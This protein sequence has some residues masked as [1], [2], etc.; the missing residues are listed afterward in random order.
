MLNFGALTGLLRR[1]P[2]YSA[3]ATLLRDGGEAGSAD[4]I[5]AARAVV[6][7]ALAEDLPAP[8][9]VVAPTVERARQLAE[10]LAMWL[11][12]RAMLFPAPEPLPYERVPW[13][14]ATNG[15][16]MRVLSAL[17]GLAG[18]Q[19]VVVASVQSLL[20]PLPSPAALRRRTRILRPG[21]EQPLTRL[22]ELLAANGY[23]HEPVTEV[24]GTYSRRGG[25][26][27]VFPVS[28]DR[29]IRIDYFG[30]MIDT[31][32]WFD[33]ETQRSQEAC[34]RAVLTPAAEAVAE[35]PAAGLAD[36]DELDCSDC[37]AAAQTDLERDREDFSQG[38][39]P[40]AFGLYLGYLYPESH[41]LLDYL[42][43]EAVVMREEFEFAD[44]AATAFW[45]DADLA[46]ERGE[47]VGDI[48]R[49]LRAPLLP[50][51]QLRDAIRERS[52]L[53]LGVG[54]EPGPASLREAFLPVTRMAGQV[55]LAVDAV[56]EAAAAGGAL[57][58]SRQAARLAELVAERGV[59]V[60]AADEVREPVRGV[61]VVHGSYPEGWALRL[62][63]VGTVTLFTDTEVFGY[64]RPARRRP[65]KRR[66]TE[67]FTI[68][69]EPG[70]YVVHV[71]HGIGRY[72]G[73]RRLPRDG[74]EREYLEIEYAGGD[75]LYVPT[76]Q[77]D[78]IS[79]YV[80][81]SEAAPSLSGLSGA[82]WQEAKARA[83]RAVEDI[84]GEL[85]ELYLARGLAEGYTFAPDDTWQR[86]LESAFPYEETEDQLRTLAQVKADMEAPRP[87]DRLIFGDVGYG[88]T[89]V[90]LRAAF[91]AVTDGKQVA[92][93]VPTTV[94]AQQH[95]ETFRGRLSAFPVTIE[96]LSRLRS[97]GD[98][99]R[100]LERLERGEVD[101]VVGTHRLVQKDVAFKDL[102]L[103]IIDEE[104][105]F[106]VR[107]KE[108]LK[109]L[110]QQV[111]VLTMTATP[112]PRTL[113][114][115]LSGLRDMSTI[116]TP[117]EDRQPVWTQ[118]SH[119]DDSL[120]ERAIR[121]ELAR[122]GQVFLV[123]DRVLGIA[124]VANRVRRL[125][126]EAVV[127]VG[128][129]QLPE[130]KLSQVME[131]FSSGAV[132][133]LV[134]TTIIES[135]LDIPN[136]NTI[137]INHADRFGLAQ[138]YQLRG[139]VGRGTARAYAYLLFSPG[140]GVTEVARQRLRAIMEA[141]ELGAGVQIAMRD[142]E[143]R[144][145]GDVLGR[146]QSGHIT[147]VGFDL[148]SRMLAQAVSQRQE[149]AGAAPT[150]EKD[151]LEAFLRPLSPGL[152]ISLPLEAELPEDYI[153]DAGLRLSLYRQLG[154]LAGEEDVDEFAAELEER[155][156][157]PPPPVE[158]LLYQTRVKVLAQHLG[159]T[160][161]G[162][163]EDQF[164][165]RMDVSL[166]RAHDIQEE[167]SGVARLG[168][169]QIRIDASRTQ[170]W[171]GLLLW[172]LRVLV[173]IMEERRAARPTRVLRPDV[174]SRQE[175]TAMEAEG[176]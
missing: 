20:M 138:L 30:D 4:V 60:S 38:Q 70:D 152:Q 120:V 81:A 11:G 175:D 78:R 13:S 22:A 111:D 79:R 44:D 63:E 69:V 165:L 87:M 108:H 106:G 137:I 130:G 168:R 146:R 49:G 54:A 131:R 23:R 89:E 119:W 32:R 123:H 129:G 171:Q 36:L 75:R 8:M 118:V 35:V 94:L 105:R 9:L 16:R 174:R 104:Q 82:D 96:M 15:A 46:R 14:P 28:Q 12:E 51:E 140:Q 149:E 169:G 100:V 83:R 128:H 5:Q 102:G 172:A 48:P 66:V 147:A 154:A 86:E 47:S 88:K 59:P 43:A 55:R 62:P 50:W 42:S 158:H 29:P 110:R 25:I 141:S 99:A 148:Y 143:I 41:S 109:R 113:N 112:I 121:R 159:A 64:S 114:L 6:L 52:V 95:Y 135:G 139:R 77:S 53:E 132:D 34:P 24:P 18:S 80:G 56:L 73:L 133:V 124:G 136:A 61:Q 37:H 57:V 101:I 97:E 58:V 142:L 160:A 67:K 127:D 27:D 98:Q 125:V 163:E 17:A 153:A 116:D 21:T 76:Y 161:V 90:A 157:P 1:A 176:R 85:L 68:D 26:L 150:L 166:L 145:A 71:E 65:R 92:V 19:P 117:P 45:Q 155:F 156:G 31:I 3:L 122:G 91:K 167:L 84:A 170:D 72:A 33:P 39:L 173:G 144:G 103:V 134:C 115:A 74:I 107:H 164:Y 10:E 2:A 7:S 93:L 126:P 162:R 151:L 40:R